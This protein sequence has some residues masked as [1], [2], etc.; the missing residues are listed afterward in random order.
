M[1]MAAGVD[2]LRLRDFRLVFGAALVSLLGD[3]MVPV[4]L[5]FA[6]LDLTG[7]A[8]DLGVVLAARSVAL[9]GSLLIGGVVADRVSRRT[10][11]VGADLVRLVGQGATGVLL[12]T[13]R[14]S[15]AELVVS[16][17]CLGAA[18][19]FFNPASSGLIPLVAGDW[20]Q[21]GNSLR[22][23]AMAAGNI[24]GP[25]IAGVLVVATSPGIALLIDAGSYGAS[26]LLLARVK[27]AMRGAVPTHRFV[28]DLREGFAEFRARTWVW[29]TI[30][31]MSVINAVAV[32]FPVLGALTA[33]RQL[34]GAG[35]WA[36]ILVGQGVGSL[37][38]GT[39][40]LQFKPRRP[41]LIGLLV[42][43]V[44]AVPMF[45]L[46]V[47][48]SL[49]LIV[50]AA[51]IGGV[52]NM[53]FNTLWETTLQQHIPEAARS[54]VSSYD[55]FGSLA[56]QSV[57]FALIGPFAAAVGTSTALYICGGLDTALVAVL[58]AIRDIR[59]V[60]SMPAGVA[61]PEH[62]ERPDHLHWPQPPVQAGEHPGRDPS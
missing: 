43:L 29:A 20:L 59:M 16:Q 15:V 37:V 60:P 27:P 36:L 49:A 32:A 48:A 58:L 28:A 30:A 56:F 18:T 51:L 23:M 13:G 8:T 19:G 62:D 41:L 5:S 57:G 7:S 4:A 53:T 54:R 6:V 38:A 17:A 24:A 42:G 26:A 45:L 52:G 14:A 10:V 21:Q 2:V 61:G 31:A 12:V 11:M 55:W 46:A 34:G 1:R 44:P 35:A 25:A 39:A 47:P 40:L 3:G 9:V 33:K 50:I 22:G